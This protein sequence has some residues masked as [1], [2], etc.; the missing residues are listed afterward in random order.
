MVY[1]AI[2]NLSWGHF[3]ENRILRQ[4]RPLHIQNLA[5]RQTAKRKRNL[6]GTVCPLHT[7][8]RRNERP[9]LGA[10][11]ESVP[12][13]HR[14]PPWGRAHVCPLIVDITNSPNTQGKRTM[15]PPGGHTGPPLRPSIEAPGNHPTNSGIFIRNPG[16]NAPF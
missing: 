10:P 5:P 16:K 1:P 4:P 9:S 13:P 3:P 14:N 12:P 6:S 15:F 11:A 7:P 2:S 8:Y